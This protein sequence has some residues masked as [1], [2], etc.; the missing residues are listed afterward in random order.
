MRIVQFMA[1]QRWGGAEKVFVELA[2]EL[3]RNHEVIA[4]LLRQT[5]Y[6]ER[7]ADPVKVVELR[8]HPT[9]HNP[10]LVREL[11][12]ALRQ[13]R[14]DIVH[15]HAAK[16]ALLIRRASL[17][18][19]VR[20]LATKHN[21]RKG[22]IFNR[23]PWVTT[24]SEEAC[25]SVL[26]RPGATVRVINNGLQPVPVPALPRSG[27]F[28]MISVGRL[29]AIK[30]FAELIEQVARLPF[31]YRLSII[32]TGPEE[33]RLRGVIHR[34]AMQDRVFLEG[35][36]DDVPVR[37]HQ[38]DLVVIS[39]H[40]EG[41]PKVMVEALFYAKVLISTPVGGVVEVLPPELLAEQHRLAEKIEQVHRDYPDCLARFAALRRER[42]QDF[43]LAAIV[44]KYEAVYRE[45]LG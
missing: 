41:F 20:H 12:C 36:K 24:V 19:P 7:F 26:V 10:L 31:A 44:G 4:L 1:S 16:A 27:P 6:R 18:C 3:A 8:A 23:L 34:L 28:S 2:N 32:G 21:A 22:R 43:L 33:E 29:D 25:R 38:A 40:S 45:M 17:F 42:A 9:S 15:T 11:V 39:S 13:L 5:E 14:P 30:G 35:F 37:M